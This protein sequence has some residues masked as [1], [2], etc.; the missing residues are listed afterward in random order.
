MSGTAAP[1]ILAADSGPTILAAD[2]GLGGLTIVAEIRKALPQARLAYLCDNAFFPYG[3]R[4]DAELLGHFLGVMNRAI[5]RVQPDLIVTAC[6]TIS[7]IC[8]PQLRAATS[9][10]VVGV[11]PAIKPA[12][13][14]SKRRIIG[15]LATP[16]T[17]NRRYTD[18][19]IQRYAAGCTV[20]R[21][22]SAELVE[23]AE[24]QLLGEA[25]DR[26]QLRRI[27]A[28]FFARPAD[29][30]PDVV[31]LACTHFPLLRAELQAA[32]PA[33]VAWIDSGTAVARRVVDVLPP[34]RGAGIASGLALTSASHGPALQR[35]LAQFGFA[36]VEAL[37]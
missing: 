7:T 33:D 2:S 13:Q 34:P 23:M 17:V 8:L 15:L 9:I 35:A 19:L 29:A 24:A 6:N 22:G 3:T 32:G 28:P 36:T 18:D 37:A 10:P 25:I 1:V 21:I 27:L 5:D 31:V 26:E 4:P 12:A 11:V 20:L 14:Q 30:Q 16:A